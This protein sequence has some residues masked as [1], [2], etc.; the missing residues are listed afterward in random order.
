MKKSHLFLLKCPQNGKPL[1]FKE[2]FAEDNDRVEAGILFEPESGSEY[3]I[4]DYIPRFVT[5]DN[6]AANF[7]LEW[8]IHSRTQYDDTSRF[9]I[10]QARFKEQTQWVDQ[11]SG[12]YILEV[13][14]GSGRFTCHAAKTGATVVS[15]DYSDAVDANWRSNGH[16]ENVLI[17]QASVF[18]MP[19]DQDFFDKAF[20]FGVLQHTPD[21]E[22]AFKSIV[23]YLKP[24]GE[25]ASDV[26]I[27]NLTRWLLQTKYYVRPFVKHLPPA[28]LYSLTQ[29]YVDLLWPLSKIIRKIPKIGY[30]INWKLLVADYS[31]ELPGAD[32]KTLKEWAY[33][34]TFDMLSPD[35]DFPQTLK[36]FKRWHIEANLQDVQVYKN[37]HGLAGRGRKPDVNDEAVGAG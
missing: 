3:K 18:D 28:R 15:L 8:N 7:G 24:G 29:K 20:C 11:L 34:D 19:F 32:D 36:T 37:G 27:K 22:Q 4:R 6:Y 30:A 25:I 21:P 12:E 10:T 2:I 23:P 16:L 5:S 9:M 31:K 17:I 35:Y 33:L 1:Q 13:G 14:S 26:Y